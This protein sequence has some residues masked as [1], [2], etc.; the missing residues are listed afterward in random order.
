MG[1]IVII[2]LWFVDTFFDLTSS[3]LAVLAEVDGDLGIINDEIWDLIF[4]I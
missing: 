2:S 1:A 3:R 4:I